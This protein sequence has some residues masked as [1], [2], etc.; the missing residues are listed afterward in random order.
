M[1]K[2]SSIPLRRLLVLTAVFALLLVCLGACGKDD[3]SDG[4]GPD[5][6]A[7]DTQPQESTGTT[8]EDPTDAATAP[9]ETEA[10]EPVMGTVTA[11]NL[12]VRSNPSTADS[13][14]LK[15]LAINTRVEILEQKTVDTTVWGRISDGWINMHYVLIDGEEPVDATEPPAETQ[16]PTTST[17]GTTGTI[18]ASELNIRKGAGSTYASVGKY[19]RG[20]TVTILEKS[21]NWGR[22]DKGWISLKYVDL[23]GEVSSTTSSGTKGTITASELN[24][25]KGAGSKYDS[26]GKYT[27]GDTVTILET[28][29]NWGRTD[30]GWISMKY[31]DLDGTADDDKDD[32]DELI[33]TPVSDGKTTV[34]GYV[35]VKSSALHVR[36]GPGTKYASADKVYQGDKVAYYQE[37]YGW[38]RIKGGWISAAYTDKDDSTTSTTTS[39]MVSDGKTTV[40]GYAV[41]NTSTL[42]ARYGP[43][44]SY[45]IAKKYSA[46]D[47]AAYYQTDGN[48]IRTKDG[49]ISKSYVYIEGTKV[50]GSS[51][52]GTITGTDLNIRTG[53]GTGYSSVGKLS[54]G[55]T[56]EILAQVTVG[57]TTWGYTSKGWVSMDYVKLG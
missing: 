38:L 52:T 4:T 29:G 8:P 27:K 50:S 41:V 5:T 7:T 46:G 31:V 23:D 21:G 2:N 26:V 17:D 40:L 34:L 3:L 16:T 6:S 44:T 14:V 36:Y 9:P 57:K 13:T 53:P 33:T 11:N 15:Q 28:S 37:Q 56:V 49:W 18:T 25:R 54:K 20:D 55:D 51:G 39:T 43:A 1:K 30:K 45:D 22:T 19:T 32:D 12:N 47:R 35:T 24:I 42:N 10:F 48:W